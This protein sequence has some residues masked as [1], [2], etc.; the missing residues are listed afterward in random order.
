[1]YEIKPPFVFSKT[2]ITIITK[3]TN[4]MGTYFT[5]L[6]L[7]FH[8]AFFIITTVF[9]LLCEPLYAGHTKLFAEAMQGP[10]NN[11]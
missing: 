5:K 6:R 8:N 2:I 7:L 1:M 3:F 10:A 4:I 11:Y 9:P